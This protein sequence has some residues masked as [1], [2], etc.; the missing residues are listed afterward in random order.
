M[1]HRLEFAGKKCIRMMLLLLGVSLAA[2]LLMAA[3]PLDLSL[4]HICGPRPGNG[5]P[6]APGPGAAGGPD[7][8][9]PVGLFRHSAGPGPQSPVRLRGGT[10][11]DN[12]HDILQL[13]R[14]VAEGA[15]AP[16]NALL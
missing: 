8:R 5:G 14:S 3:S 2:F 4:I 12:K 15:T 9:P 1:R 11:M 6:A 10:S 16:E 13:L 7:G